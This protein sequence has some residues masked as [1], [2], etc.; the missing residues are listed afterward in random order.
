MRQLQQEGQWPPHRHHPLQKACVKLPA[1]AGRGCQRSESSRPEHSSTVTAHWMRKWPQV[2]TGAGQDVRHSRKRSSCVSLLCTSVCPAAWSTGS[3]Q[4][5]R[6]LIGYL[7]F[8]LLM[9]KLISILTIMIPRRIRI[10]K[11]TCRRCG[12]SWAPRQNNPRQCP[13]CK[14]AYWDVPPEDSRSKHNP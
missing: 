5:R 13:R 7:T 8:S 11:L 4:L 3:C 9:S 10:R 2:H 1:S 12:H 6:S 14:S